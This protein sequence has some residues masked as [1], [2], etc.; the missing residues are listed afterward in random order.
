MFCLLP[1]LFLLPPL[2]ACSPDDQLD[3]M[4]YGCFGTSSNFINPVFLRPDCNRKVFGYSYQDTHLAS[5]DSPGYGFS[6]AWVNRTLNLLFMLSYA[7]DQRRFV[8]VIVGVM[9][10]G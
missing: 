10:A 7:L 6:V 3:H 4:V 5:A 9:A 8:L 1:I 2:L